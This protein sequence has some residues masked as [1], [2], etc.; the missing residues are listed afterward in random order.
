M[1]L[2]R[3]HLKEA[4][5]VPVATTV[6]EPFFSTQLSSQSQLGPV[7]YSDLLLVVKHKFCT[8]LEWCQHQYF[9]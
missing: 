2:S 3:T 6:D 1:L 4:R 7:P 5:S 8:I 9:C